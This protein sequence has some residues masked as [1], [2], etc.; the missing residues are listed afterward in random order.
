LRQLLVLGATSVIKV[1]NPRVE[2]AGK[3]PTGHRYATS[4]LMGLLE[5]RPRRV[6]AVALANKMARIVWAMMTTGEA[7]RQPPAIA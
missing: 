5:R 3:R 2:P 7:Y 6:A 1:A 4:W